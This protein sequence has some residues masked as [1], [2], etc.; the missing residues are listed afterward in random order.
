MKTAFAV[1][2]VFASICLLGQAASGFSPKIPQGSLLV[3][4]SG[5]NTGYDCESKATIKRTANYVINLKES[6]NMDS[7]DKKPSS[8]KDTDAKP[9]KKTTKEEK[10]PVKKEKPSS[11]KLSDDLKKK[12]E[13][14]KKKLKKDST[15]QKTKTQ[16]T[17]HDTVKNSI[18]NIR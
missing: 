15:T 6:L 2:A 7:N 14:I 4:L 18:N 9:T 3:A 8:K 1:L 13:Q 5:C 16:K 17:K 12:F 10:K 11:K